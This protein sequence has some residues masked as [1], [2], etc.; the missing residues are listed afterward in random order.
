MPHPDQPVKI[1]TGEGSIKPGLIQAL[2]L[3]FYKHLLREER[4]ALR[5]TCHVFRELHDQEVKSITIGKNGPIL[6]IKFPTAVEVSLTVRGALTRGCR[7][8]EVAVNM[9]AFDVSDVSAPEDSMLAL[10]DSLAGANSVE[11]FCF[12]SRTPLKEAVAL[13]VSAAIPNLACMYLSASRPDGADVQPPAA[14]LLQL[15]GPKLKS[16]GLCAHKA[17]WPA[18]ALE[19][20]TLCSALTKLSFSMD[21]DN[22]EVERGLVAESTLRRSL[23]SLTGLQELRLWGGVHPPADTAVRQVRAAALESC[24]SS[25]TGLTSLDIHVRCLEHVQHP[26]V[27]LRDN[28]EEEVEVQVSQLQAEGRAEEAARLL[29]AVDAES[30]ALAAALR[31]MPQLKEFRALAR[32]NAADL[33][34]LTA[35]TYLRVGAI[36]LPQQAHDNQLQRTPVYDLP[37][38]LERLKVYAPLSMRVAASLRR[39]PAAAAAGAPLI[40]WRAPGLL[41]RG[42]QPFWSL[43]FSRSDLDDEDRLTA[44]A[45]AR[46][47]PAATNLASS[48]ERA[49]PAKSRGLLLR[50]FTCQTEK[51]VGPPSSAAGA[52]LVATQGTAAAAVA[53]GG[54]GTHCGSWLGSMVLEL[55]PEELRLRGFEFSARDM[56]G[57]ARCS[58]GLR[59]LD[60][61]GCS[62]SLSS[63]PLLGGLAALESLTLSF[64][65]WTGFDWEAASSTDALRAAFLALTAPTVRSGRW[66]KEDSDVDGLYEE[67]DALP[68]PRLKRLSIDAIE[69]VT[70]HWLRQE[71]AVVNS[72][73]GRRRPNPAVLIVYTDSDAIEQGLDVLD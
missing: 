63:L 60:L 29:A 11:S 24:L 30:R 45:A 65:D 8:K 26:D 67:E 52:A 69:G 55:Q 47:H 44:A 46:V 57:I 68:L 2:R 64:E 38:L 73:L 25:L 6:P 62:Y 22:E 42:D 16:L 53:G 41:L 48:F 3:I 34:P 35:L 49:A 37:P 15:V 50:V 72:E 4:L 14:L 5:E 32:V 10:L 39:S 33:A 1:A 66:I 23:S 28:N 71:L 56:L 12:H 31:C 17:A 7:P 36:V 43:E 9:H 13:A 40:S 70:Q 51:Y 54:D 59:A 58:A 27:Q 18:Q 20:L 61:R 21:W 19:T